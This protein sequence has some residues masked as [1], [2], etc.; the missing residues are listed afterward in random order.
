[1]SEGKVVKKSSN[2][3]YY[4]VKG[5][6]KK[7]VFL[8]VLVFIVFVAIVV[9]LLSGSLPRGDKMVSEKLDMLDRFVNP[10][11]LTRYSI[12]AG[13]S[14]QGIS[15]IV[16]CIPEDIP[17]LFGLIKNI[18]K[19]T[20]KP[21]EVVIGMSEVTT[22]K[23]QAT[24]EEL[25]RLAEGYD[26][27]IVSVAK[28]AYAGGNRNRAVQGSKGDLLFFID[29]DDTM[30]SHR[31]DIVTRLFERLDQKPAMVLHGYRNGLKSTQ[32]QDDLV[33]HKY[34]TKDI[35]ELVVKPHV[36]H[37][38]RMKRRHHPNAPL[39]GHRIHHGHPVVKRWVFKHLQ[40]D[41]G[42]RRGQDSGFINQVLYKYKGGENSVYHLKLPLTNYVIRS[43][44]K[45]L[46]K[47][48][49]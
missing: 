17:K 41:P 8:G 46:A 7:N 43:K 19:Q 40:Y 47:K 5:G 18:N 25:R 10:P 44:Q 6:E 16:P 24:E 2:H 14:N 27:K 36:L 45:R 1:M 20:R 11:D 29:A 42:R 23:A 33:L 15:V 39:Y 48:R 3:L 49:T 22:K 28:P 38:S 21:D 26:V 13:P 12:S 34:N 37:K 4:Y 35:D 30:N 31:I 9:L 32:R